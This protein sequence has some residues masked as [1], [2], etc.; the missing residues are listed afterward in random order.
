MTPLR[1]LCIN[2]AKGFIMQAQISIKIRVGPSCEARLY[3]VLWRKKDL[4]YD[5]SSSLALDYNLM[6]RIGVYSLARLYKK[7]QQPPQERRCLWGAK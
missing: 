1:A 6:T 2:L 3:L 4:F 7:K 5:S